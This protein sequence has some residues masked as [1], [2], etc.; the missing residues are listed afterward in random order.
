MYRLLALAKY[1]ERYVI[2]PTH[3]EQAHAL[4]EL[5]TECALD[6]EGGP[7][8]GGWGPFGE[9]SGGPSPIAVENFQMLRDRQTSDTMAA[10]DDKGTR[11]NLL[12]WDGKGSPSGLFPPRPDAPA[13]TDATAGLTGGTGA[14]EQGGPQ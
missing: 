1:D 4:E 5:A 2:P 10:P 9:G 14:D 8:M 6:Y 7:G 12:N 3:A 11:V 13:E